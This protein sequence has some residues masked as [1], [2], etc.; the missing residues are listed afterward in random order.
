MSYDKDRVTHKLQVTCGVPQGSILGPLLFL[1]YVNDLF[2]ASKI[3]SPIMFAD[4]TNLFYADRNIEKLF[5]IVNAELKNITEWFRANKLSLNVKKTKYLLFHSQTKKITTSL[6]KITMDSIE[7]QRE[8]STKFLGIILDESLS[9]K[10]QTENV[11]KKVSKGIRLLYSARPYL[12]KN[13][14]TQMYYAFVHCHIN[15]CNIAWGSTHKSKLEPLHRKQ[16]HA[17]RIINQRDR[18]THTE[19]LFQNLK[20]LNIFA[21]NIFQ[22]LCLMYKCREKQGPRIFHNVFT[23]KSHGKY[24]IRTSQKTVAEPIS[25][26]SYELFSFSHRGPRLWNKFVAKNN[27]LLNTASFYAFKKNLKVLLLKQKD[28][29]TIY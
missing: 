15:Y 18:M 26:R 17:V 16:K 20:I 8:Y 11:N 23:L 14:L 1:I 27:V 24:S 2:A 22:T 10:I 21:L 5:E 4:D 13:L 9:W 6:P 28:F 29:S 12:T 3:L 7:I 25:H 19:P